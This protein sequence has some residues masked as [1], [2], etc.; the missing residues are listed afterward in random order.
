MKTAF[1]FAAAL[2]LFT[3]VA[4]SKDDAAVDPEGTVSLNMLNY[5]NG[6]TQLG[7]MNLRIDS[8]DN[9]SCV[10]CKIAEMGPVSG[11]SAI[12]RHIFT[13]LA[14]R[15]AVKEGYGYAVYRDDDIV[16]FPSGAKAMLADAVYY[17]MRVESRLTDS[18]THESMGAHVKYIAT[19]AERYSL[20][21]PD[22]NEYDMSG[23]YQYWV[24]ELPLDKIDEMF[25]DR[26]LTIE[27]IGT[28][29]GEMV[30]ISRPNYGGDTSGY[31]RLYLRQKDVWSYVSILIG[32]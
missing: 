19:R 32:Y 7:N 13:N 25:V 30:L 4:C 29:E 10:N 12:D 3:A 15:V 16:E 17:R 14:P 28:P 22:A 2:L 23:S 26:P 21:M 27:Q 1:P 11:L 8:S 6:G 20:P 31:Y 9:F 18:E 24:T 5:E